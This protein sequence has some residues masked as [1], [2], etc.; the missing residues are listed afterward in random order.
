MN[1]REA[2]QRIQQLVEL[3]N[4]HSELYHTND[5]P[6]ISDEAYD[7]LYHE[8]VALEHTFPHLRPDHSPTLRAGDL[9]KDDLEKFTH[10]YRQWSLDNIFN[11]RELT[12]WDTRIKKLLPEHT[13][14]S[15]T[16]QPKID[17]LK[18]VLHYKQGI[19]THAVTRGD[20]LVGEDVI[21]TVRT[22]KNVPLDLGQPIDAV[23]IGEVW[24]P[25]SAL[26]RINH[27]R[28]QEGLPTYAN[29]RNL[30]AGTLR[31]LDARVAASR[32]LQMF[33]YDVD[34]MGGRD[35]FSSYTALLTK[36]Q[37]LGFT[38]LPHTE[39]YTDLISLQNYYE[40]WTNH[41]RGQEYSIDGAVIK[42]DEMNLWQELGY[43]A[44]APRFAIAYKF[45]AEEATT[46]VVGIHVQVGRTGALTPVAQLVPVV[47]DG[48]T[49][50]HASLHNQDEI[51][52]LD[53]R[54]GD[55]V[56]I[57]KA[58]DIIP[59]V[60]R[61]MKELRTG[62]EKKFSIEVY[63]QSQKWKIRKDDNTGD[64]VVWYLDDAT[65]AEIKK[66]KI[67]HF[68]SKKAMNI[69]G[70][71]EKTVERF[72]EERIITDASDIFEMDRER[73]LALEG[74]KEK[75]VENLF[76]AVKSAQE[77]ELYRFLFALGIR[78]IGEETA[79]LIAR[80]LQT[81]SSQWKNSID[82]VNSFHGMTFDNLQKVEGIGDVVAESFI[83][84]F[85]DRENID[86]VK[87]LLKH[88]S[89]NIKKSKSK[90]TFQGKTFVITGTLPTLSRD[91]AKELVIQHGGKVASSVSKNTDY[92]LA[93]EKA[94][95]KL[96]KAE[97]LEVEVIDEEEFKKML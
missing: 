45:P 11:N 42:V 29:P 15:Y 36:L 13:P 57:K 28:E 5:A 17:G 7:S 41:R 44:K 82:T 24:L 85:E 47:V 87:R 14:V 22:I 27:E 97:E 49:V 30:A 78:H 72:L 1:T 16:I 76:E 32:N 37:E 56:I 90:T 81:E 68:V 84:F 55:T 94:G 33:V 26:V 66:Q 54:I 62:K 8:L 46:R 65:N 64:S 50:S 43:T 2:Q 67:I 69:D 88:I 34:A 96:Q 92:V 52:R 53:V 51:D 61:A 48:S 38:T 20:G 77:V 19:L 6:E 18:I 63:A 73:I 60:L 10:T 21:H 31:Q 40:Y 83:E 58:G 93:G 70:M 91:E 95:S 80:E 23:I 25:K 89:L 79:R 86:F 4:Y 9:I 74:F 71:G 75:S 12:A 3:I 35:D 59:K 39:H